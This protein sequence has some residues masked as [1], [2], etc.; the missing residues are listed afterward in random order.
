MRKSVGFAEYAN[1]SSMVG[2]ILNNTN[3]TLHELDTIYDYED[4]CDIYEA[5]IVKSYNE[6]CAMNQKDNK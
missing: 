3:V 4:A 1:L 2:T 5:V 6:W